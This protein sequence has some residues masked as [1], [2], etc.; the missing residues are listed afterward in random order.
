V[1]LSFYVFQGMYT[2]SQSILEFCKEIYSL[3]SKISEHW[4]YTENMTLIEKNL[5]NGKWSLCRLHIE[6][7]ASTNFHQALLEEM[8]VYILEG[9]IDKA[10]EV[11]NTILMNLNISSFEAADLS[12]LSN[13]N[14]T[15]QFEFWSEKMSIK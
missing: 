1:F 8:N 3:S 14:A 4:I 11:G 5:L 9:N 13:N 10:K 7:L 12:N 6:K 15:S 2:T